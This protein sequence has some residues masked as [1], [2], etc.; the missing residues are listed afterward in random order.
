VDPLDE[1]RNRFDLI[2]RLV[3]EGCDATEH[4]DA[5]QGAEDAFYIFVKIGDVLTG[6]YKDSSDV[7]VMRYVE[8]MQSVVDAAIASVEAETKPPLVGV[9]S[10]DQPWTQARAKLAAAV[11]AFRLGQGEK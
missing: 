2:R 3:S 1:I 8:S 10:R 7:E 6:E 9:P 4:S 11:E 5:K